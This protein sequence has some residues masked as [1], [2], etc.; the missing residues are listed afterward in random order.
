MNMYQD[1]VKRLMKSSDIP[2]VGRNQTDPI[3]DSLLFS[4]RCLAER[5]VNDW[6]GQNHVDVNVFNV[7]TA[8]DALGLLNRSKVREE[9]SKAIK[10]A[11]QDNGR[12]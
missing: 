1:A 5:M 8:L 12:T 6:M 2:V 3:D 9:Y 10:P 7:I 11:R 4:Q